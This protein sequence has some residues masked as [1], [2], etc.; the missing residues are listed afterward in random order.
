MFE[1]LVGSHRYSTLAHDMVLLSAVYGT[2]L[3]AFARFGPAGSL[4]YTG[5]GRTQRRPER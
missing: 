3:Q 2:L 5:F 4:I 1:R